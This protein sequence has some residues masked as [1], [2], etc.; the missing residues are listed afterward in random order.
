MMAKST[1]SALPWSAER[2]AVASGGKRS[3]ASMDR[4]CPAF[5]KAPLRR[6]RLSAMSFACSTRARTSDS[7]NAS[8]EAIRDCN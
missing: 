2:M 3:L 5:M 1:G 4:S 6:P 8:E 7:L